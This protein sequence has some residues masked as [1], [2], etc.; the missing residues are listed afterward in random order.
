MKLELKK[1]KVA[2][3]VLYIFYTVGICGFLMPEFIS[4][5]KHLIPLALL[6]S[7][8]LLV[9]CQPKEFVKRLFIFVFTGIYFSGLIIEMI[10]VNTGVIFGEYTY[11]SNL[12]F[13]LFN[14]PII[15]GLNWLILVYTTSSIFEKLSIH[16]AYKILMASSCMLVYD[17]VLEQTAPKLG[18]WNWNGKEVPLNNYLAW[19]IIAVIFQSV[20]KL[21]GIKTENAIAKN[22]F[23]IQFLFN[24]LERKSI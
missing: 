17:I 15:I 7:F 23:I 19:F 1:E 16:S 5:F 10:G 8:I 4:F 12:G 18:M 9:V 11:G 2:Q 14:T 3:K 20:I 13:K 6:L 21:A 22:L 24:V